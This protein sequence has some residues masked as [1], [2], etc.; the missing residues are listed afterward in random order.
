MFTLQLMNL[1]IK[2]VIKCIIILDTNIR[3]LNWCSLLQT[4]YIPILNERWFFIQSKYKLREINGLVWKE[5]SMKLYRD[6]CVCEHT[7]YPIF[8]FINRF[9]LKYLRKRVFYVWTALH[10]KVK[11]EKLEYSLNW[12][13]SPYWC[14]TLWPLTWSGFSKNKKNSQKNTVTDIVLVI[15]ENTASL[16][17]NQK[18]TGIVSKSKCHDLMF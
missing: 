1:F 3:H 9:A 17:A 14:S 8:I 18:L 15:P 6:V 10:V 11:S 2:R 16:L 12:F 7:I 5:F 4:S 13:C